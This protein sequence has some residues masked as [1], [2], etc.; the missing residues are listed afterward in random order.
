MGLRSCGLDSLE[1][2]RAL[3]QVLPRRWCCRFARWKPGRNSESVIVRPASKEL[4]SW[5]LREVKHLM[6]WVVLI[7]VA[8]MLI[9]VVRQGQGPKD[10]ELSFSQFM[11][12]VKAG[13]VAKVTVAANDVHGEMRNPTQQLHTT[14]PLNYPNIYD[15]MKA[16]NPPV[17]VT[18]K[19]TSSGTW[20]SILLQASP[21]IVL[22]AFWIFM[23]RQD[24]KSTRLNSSHFGSS[25]SV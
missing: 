8:G 12:E 13:R 20:L 6:L 25:Y 18:I 3:P 24:R 16:A 1:W 2:Q 14:V 22:A 23:V 5:R 15:L 17:D 19:D 9:F 10:Q 11:D 7:A 21:F 4:G